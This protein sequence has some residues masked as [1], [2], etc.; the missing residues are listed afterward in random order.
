MNT[1]K[2]PL[3]AL[4]AQIGR[5]L[6][7]GPAADMAEQVKKVVEDSLA[8]FRLVPHHEFERQLRALGEL[9]RQVGELAR[10]VAVL[11]TADD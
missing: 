2:S 8:A 9:E 1:P 7:G 3:D 5:L 10:R 4:L 11:E 6:E